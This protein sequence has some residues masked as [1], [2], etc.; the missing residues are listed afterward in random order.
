MGCPQ[1]I[2]NF[3]V[4]VNVLGEHAASV[5]RIEV[6]IHVHVLLA[7]YLM[8]RGAQIFQTGVISKF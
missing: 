1:P 6:R 4:D 8:L 3:S 5:F 7:S 2:L